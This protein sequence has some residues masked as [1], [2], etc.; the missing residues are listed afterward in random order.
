MRHI[1]R[2]LT[3]AAFAFALV[4]MPAIAAHDSKSLPEVRVVATGGTIA[5]E[6]R[7]PCSSATTRWTTYSSMAKSIA[8]RAIILP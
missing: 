7:D 1:A 4:W 5:G 2:P 6:Q 8:G 3:A